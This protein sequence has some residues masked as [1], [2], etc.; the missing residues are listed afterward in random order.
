MPVKNIIG[1]IRNNIVTVTR[2]EPNKENDHTTPSAEALPK[3]V[4]ESIELPL[5]ESEDIVPDQENVESTSRGTFSKGSSIQH[6][7]EPNISHSN[8]EAEFNAL[9]TSMNDD[10]DYS[11][12]V[13][14]DCNIK[15]QE[16]SVPMSLQQPT[17]NVDL[18][19]WDNEDSKSVPD[20]NKNIVS[21]GGEGLSSL[22]GRIRKI[23]KRMV[24]ARESNDKVDQMSE[25]TCEEHVGD[26][27]EHNHS[28]DVKHDQKH[29]ASVAKN[30]INEE[31]YDGSIQLKR[32]QEHE[33]FDADNSS[34]KGKRD[35]LPHDNHH[36][37]PAGDIENSSDE[38]DNN[39]FIR[40]KHDQE[41][42]VCGAE[43]ARNGLQKDKTNPVEENWN[44]VEEVDSAKQG[45]N[46]LELQECPV[47][48]ICATDNEVVIETSRIQNE[49][50]T[51]F[52]DSLDNNTLNSEFETNGTVVISTSDPDDEVEFI[53]DLFA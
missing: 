24:E 23:R 52:S 30:V 14:E 21:P 43:I 45:R 13:K 49:A 17:T 1:L 47:Q 42:E 53:G 33:A 8:G 46:S 32:D 5:Q 19:L 6:T 39:D 11:E 9:E 28:T 50:S 31:K 34:G 48:S 35:N 22:L 16:N 25:A 7:D 26:K 4:N 3:E 10:S 27:G 18:L 51:Q 38:G 37:K 36:Q 2:D 41:L 29:E 44:V 20:R 40:A 12:S 15:S